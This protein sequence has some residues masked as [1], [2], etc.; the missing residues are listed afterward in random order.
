MIIARRNRKLLRMAATMKQLSVVINPG[1]V[2]E[3]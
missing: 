3:S 2:T 1:F